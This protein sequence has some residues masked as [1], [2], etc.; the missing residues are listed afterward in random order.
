MPTRAYD[1]ASPDVYRL[2]VDNDLIP[3]RFE[4]SIGW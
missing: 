1:H 4:R 3:Y 2:P